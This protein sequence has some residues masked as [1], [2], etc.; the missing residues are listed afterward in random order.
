MEPS[1]DISK[2]KLVKEKAIYDE[3]VSS[4]DILHRNLMGYH[5][6]FAPCKMKEE[7]TLLT[8]LLEPGVI[9]I[10]YMKRYQKTSSAVKLV[11]C[12]NIWGK[13][14]YRSEKILNFLKSLNPKEIKEF[15]MY[16]IN[17]VARPIPRKIFC[18]YARL[19]PFVTESI[20][21]A[22]LK[23]SEKQ[24]NCIFRYCQPSQKLHFDQ[25]RIEAQHF[26]EKI[27][28]KTLEIRK[29]YDMSMIVCKFFEHLANCEEVEKLILESNIKKKNM[30]KLVEK[31]QVTWISIL[32]CFDSP[33]SFYRI[34]PTSG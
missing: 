5:H 11:S 30:E 10:P 21:L 17:D 29:L 33:G 25:C 22:K 2:R 32:N 1:Q 18:Q 4:M 13:K 24:L 12:L 31:Y 9:E 7:G 14:G 27:K 19:F 23:I 6:K 3:E 20:S 15:I 34:Y 26:K 28:V 16:Y 8:F